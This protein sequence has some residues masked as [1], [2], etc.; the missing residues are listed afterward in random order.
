MEGAQIRYETIYKNIIKD[1]R[2][3]V[4]RRLGVKYRS[5]VSGKKVKIRPKPSLKEITDLLHDLKKDGT[6]KRREIATLEF[7]CLTSPS[8]EEKEL[9]EKTDKTTFETVNG[10][11]ESFNLVV[12]EKFIGNETIR[13]ALEDYLENCPEKAIET[14]RSFRQHKAAY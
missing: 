8:P 11:M 2:R 3:S 7:L 4:M 13:L 1:F 9:A 14:K 12:M 6:A 10:V 5:R